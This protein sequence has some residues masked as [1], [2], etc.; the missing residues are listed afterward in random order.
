MDNEVGFLNQEIQK[1]QEFLFIDLE[2]IDNQLYKEI[3][4]SGMQESAVL[5]K[6]A[7]EEDAKNVLLMILQSRRMESVVEDNRIH[8]TKPHFEYQRLVNNTT[9]K[10]KNKIQEIEDYLTEKISKW[11]CEQKQNPFTA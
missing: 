4:L 6:I 7:T 2:Q 5:A 3:D 10:L 1:S 11:I 8:I 9:K